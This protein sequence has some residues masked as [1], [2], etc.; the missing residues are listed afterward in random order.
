[1]D[2]YCANCHQQNGRGD[3]NRF[4]PLVGSEYVTG[5]KDRLIGIILNGLQGQISVA[6]KSYNGMMPA[7]GGYLDDHAIASIVT[8]IRARFGKN[9]SDAT[10][11]EVTNV[12]KGGAAPKKG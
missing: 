9:A 8:Y 6:G 4:P 10:T 3:N 1:F 2:T 5:D 11:L 7:H 12:R